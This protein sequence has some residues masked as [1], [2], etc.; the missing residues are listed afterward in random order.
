MN[1][2]SEHKWGEE[3]GGGVN[4]L[5]KTGKVMVKNIEMG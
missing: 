1:N 2:H 4:M 5:K 3:T